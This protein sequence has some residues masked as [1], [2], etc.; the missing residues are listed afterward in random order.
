MCQ[1][2]IWL[3]PIRVT[4][5]TSQRVVAVATS[6]FVFVGKIVFVVAVEAIEHGRDACR[7]TEG[8]VNVVVSHERERMLER[9]R[10]PRRR[11]VALLAVLRKAQSYV[12]WPARKVVGMARIAVRWNRLEV[13]T[14]VTTRAE[15]TCMRSGEQEEVM[16]EVPA[17]P[18]GSSMASLAVGNPAVRHVVGCLG[19]CEAPLVAE[20]ALSRRPA[21][22]ADSGLEVAALTGSHRVGGDQME[23]C[24][25]MLCDKPG[26]RPVDLAVAALAI[27]SQRRGMRVGVAPPAASQ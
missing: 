14:D 9:R 4:L 7:V 5:I 20:L 8:T 1:L 21:E 2:I 10:R 11:A 22:L 27:K 6:P 24:L 13:A 12:I 3:P 18:T 25:G 16:L 26:R 19:L 17:F 23:T 15:Q